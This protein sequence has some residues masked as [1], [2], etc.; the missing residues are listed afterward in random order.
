MATMTERG[1]ALTAL[2]WAVPLSLAIWALGAW[3]AWTLL[4]AE[5]FGHSEHLGAL[6][7]A[8]LAAPNVRR[9]NATACGASSGL[10][11]PYVATSLPQAGHQPGVQ[12]MAASLN[13]WGTSPATASHS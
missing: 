8:Y 7:S 5:P 11:P 9:G 1:N 12:Y 6:E 4:A 3:L 2:R 10:I 13:A